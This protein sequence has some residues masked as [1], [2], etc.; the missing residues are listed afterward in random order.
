[1][2]SHRVIDDPQWGYKHLDPIPSDEETSR[3]Y[4]KQYYDLIRQGG[5]APELRRL[6]RG[7]EEAQTESAWMRATLY[8][9]IEYMARSHAPGMKVLDI[10]CGTGDLLAYL[11]SRGFNVTGIEPSQEAASRAQ[12]RGLTVH[13]TNLADFVGSC[14][15]GKHPKF[16]L[17]TMVNVLEH[18]SNPVEIL[19]TVKPLLESRGCIY[20]RVPNDFTEIQEAARLKTGK[21]PWWIATPDHICYFNF[22]SLCGLLE[23]LGWEVMLRQGDFPMELF[24]LMGDVYVDNPEIG[25]QCHRKRMEFE[26]GVPPEFRRRIYQAL[27]QIGIGRDCC[28]LA[29]VRS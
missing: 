3:F 7:G 19:Q 11:Q 13:E 8:Q 25:R 17:I 23:K 20:L 5:R 14:R 22:K 10:G 6:M 16:D 29:R 12:E 2:S 18:V 4:K 28:V 9:D 24:L 15:D 1:M 26:L 21:S 27:A